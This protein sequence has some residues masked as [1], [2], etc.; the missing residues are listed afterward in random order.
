MAPLIF[1]VLLLAALRSPRT[2]CTATRSSR[3]AALVFSKLSS[4]A[5]C[6][7]QVI[8]MPKELEQEQVL[9]FHPALLPVPHNTGYCTSVRYDKFVQ[10]FLRDVN[11]GHC[12]VDGGCGGRKK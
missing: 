12:Q 4:P 10:S 11:S 2:P 7:P 9:N 6:A 8:A 5:S 1:S 3:R